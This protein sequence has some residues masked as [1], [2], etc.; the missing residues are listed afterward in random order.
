MNAP[1]AVSEHITLADLRDPGEVARIEGF[2][3]AHGGTAFHRP[4]WLMAA[5][6]GCGQ[7]ALGLMATRAGELTGWFPLTEVHSPL[8]GRAL[9]SSGFAVG[10]GVLAHNDATAQ[11]LCNAATELALRRACGTVELR[12][13]FMPPGWTIARDKH[14]GFAA[15]LA[16][17]DAAQL[18]AIPRKHR[19]EV[20]KGLAADFTISVGASD[21]DRAAHHAVYAESVLKLGTPVFPRALFDAMLDAFG[22]D[23]DILTVRRAGV[24]VASVLS[25]YHAG[26]VLPYWGGGTRAA[27]AL[28]ANERLYFEL[29][30]HAR[31]RGCTRFDFG[32]SKSGSG[33][34]A[35]K[36][37]WG[38]V[39][40]PLSY[41][42]WTAPGAQARNVDP[43]SDAYSAR[44]AMWR[45]LPLSLANRIGPTI[46]RG[47]T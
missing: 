21:A 42:T 30:H 25:F 34:W 18:L 36:K 40:Q 2:V 46:A 8:F 39:P 44:I 31:S 32:R 11:R 5:E 17:D 35:Y 9:V 7:R 13:G 26:A 37:N 23:A 14:C 38:F 24:P 29:M 28:R 47:L 12:G 33:P 16:A 4:A 3:A 19:A 41:A 20:R 15:D 43:A 45:R 27:R 6:R 1:L 22:A 10:G